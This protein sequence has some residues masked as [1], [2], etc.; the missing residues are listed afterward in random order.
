MLF[1]SLTFFVFFLG[2]YAL[3]LSFR[4][5]EKKIILITVGSYLFYGFWNF[6]FILLLLVSTLVDFN[7]GKALL[8]VSV[9]KKRK[10]LLFLSIAVNLGMLFVFKYYNLF[11][12]ASIGL[13]SLLGFAWRPPFID[14]VLPVGISFYTFQT[15][16]YT[17]DLYYKKIETE[18]SFW[19]FAAFVSF[20]PQLVAGPILRAKEF[21][22]QFK[23]NR[24]F[25]WEIFYQGFFLII[26]G[27]F[28][29]AVIADNL[30]PY[31]ERVYDNNF[32]VSI[33]D[34]WFSTLAFTFQIYMDF[35]G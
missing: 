7:I 12:S 18:K 4:V 19:T 33:T 32:A 35:S 3:Y 15:L 2:F 1:N 9:Q 5:K 31:V 8:N 17:I 21:I 26:F 14:V 23:K 22:P 13:L 20:F 25:S 27:L 34:A 6:P 24:A 30:A 10:A 28:K 29:K 16:S 11:A